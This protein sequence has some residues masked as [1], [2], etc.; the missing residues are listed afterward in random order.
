M[1]QGSYDTSAGYSSSI[2]SSNRINV[3]LSRAKHG[4]YILGN[5]ANLRKNETWSTII[6]EMEARDQ[7]GQGLP[8]VCPRHPDQK[9]IITKPGELTHLA[10]GGGCLLPCGFRLE[11]GHICPSAVRPSYLVLYVKSNRIRT[12]S[13]CPRQPSHHKMFHALQQNSLPSC[14]SVLTKMLR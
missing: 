7:I 5:A 12:V 11:C 6:N 10:P 3:A 8:I 1:C 13:R 14:S 2:Q 9:Q 4:L